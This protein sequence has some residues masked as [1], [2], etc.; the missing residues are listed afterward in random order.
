[1]A[2]LV[3]V[4]GWFATLPFASSAFGK[5]K[6]EESSATFTHTYD[7]V[8]QAAQEA[9]ERLGLFVTNTDKNR[10][11]VS[12]KGV[13]SG[14]QAAQWPMK[15]TFDVHIE[16][17]SPKPETRVTIDVQRKA[18]ISGRGVSSNVF[19]SAYLSELQKVLATYK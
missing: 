14:G 5:D 16:T 7:E 18:K 8:F 9:T 12:G 10:G 6:A 1:M 3:V 15:L 2:S 11:V 13:Y 19:K 4:L 17:V